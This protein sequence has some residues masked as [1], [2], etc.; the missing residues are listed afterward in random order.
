MSCSTKRKTE[1][2][3]PDCKWIVGVGC[4]KSTWNGPKEKPIVVNV[5][6]EKQFSP[7]RVSPVQQRVSPKKIPCYK[8]RKA[9]CVGPDCK[10]IVGVGCR[11]EEQRVSPVRQR[12]SPVRQRV[13]PVKQ[14]IRQI[15]EPRDEDYK[16]QIGL[17]EYVFSDNLDV[18][19]VKI[20]QNKIEI[21]NPYTRSQY[22]LKKSKILGEGTY[23]KVIKYTD[24]QNKVFLA[25]KFA[26][27]K[28]EEEV[29]NSLK[30][31]GCEV[32]KVKFC[33]EIR[34]EDKFNYVF[35]TELADGDLQSW[36]KKYPR[37]IPLETLNNVLTSI[38]KQLNCLLQHGLLYTDL[39]ISNILFKCDDPD[40][41]GENNVRIILGDI[42]SL[43]YEKILNGR[44]YLSTYPPIE[45][46]QLYGPGYIFIR[47]NDPDRESKMEKILCWEFGIVIL[48]LLPYLEGINNQHR[49]MIQNFVSQLSHKY[50][51]TITSKEIFETL[52]KI[53]SINTTKFDLIKYL[54]PKAPD[55]KWNL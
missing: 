12:V 3:G 54:N 32:L 4:R 40:Y 10:W 19:L 13:S 20:S 25:A 29:S 55:R 21:K 53:N 14:P 38:W 50:I 33:K 49:R 22:I 37:G 42:G 41:L 52:N 35:F 6:E 5:V 47:E 30:N 1:C 16:N 8:K 7:R 46:I 51:S 24:R 45:T 48:Q 15:C 11:K 31:I 34:Q 23:G 27:D 18:N 44:R 9:E 26:K 17:E 39:K 28:D 43:H 2:V 36:V